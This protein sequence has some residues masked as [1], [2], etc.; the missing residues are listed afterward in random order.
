MDIYATQNK[1]V[2][3]YWLKKTQ[4][5]EVLSSFSSN[6]I[7]SSKLIL[8]TNSL[9]YFNKL[10]G[11]QL[12][13]EYTVLLSIYS[14]LIKKYFIDFDGFIFSKNTLQEEIVNANS[15]LF[16]ITT[17]QHLS[18]KTHLQRVKKE[19]QETLSY[20]QYNREELKHKIVNVNLEGLTPFSF[21]YV[22]SNESSQTPFQ[23]NV[24]KNTKGDIEAQI[25]YSRNFL[26][27][28]VVE[29]FLKNIGRILVNLED[30]LNV[31]INKISILSDKE[32][33]LITKHFNNTAVDYPRNRTI[34]DLFEEKVT[35][36]PNNTAVAFED[37]EIT[38]KELN[39]CTNQLAHYLR[40]EH[41]IQ[42][43]DLIGI[44]LERSEWLIVIIL[45]ILKAGA[46]YV[47][48]DSSYPQ[49]RI[50][51]IVKD[52]GLKV[53]I[54]E[55]ELAIFKL[56]SVKYS[57]VNIS[58]V[59][60]SDQLAY[61][62]Y[63]S[64]STG[65]PKGVLNSHEGL[66]NRLLWMRDYL[67]VTSTDIFLQKTPYTFDVSVWEFLLPLITGCVLVIAE[68]EG[69]KDPI[70][71]QELIRKKK[72]TIVHFVPSMLSVFL[73]G[74]DLD[75]CKS[76][77]HIICSGEALT[78]NIVEQ[79]KAKLKH[80]SIHNFYGPTEAAI[81]VT[82]I[83]LTNVKV[84]EQGVSIG[85]PVSNTKIYI[86]NE[87]GDLQPI[88]IPGE[89]LISGVQV[90]KGYLNLPQLTKER[91]IEDPFTKGNRMYRTGD[92][93]KWLPDGSIQYLG[94]RDHQ[95]KI[96]GYRIEL[97]E[98]ESNILEYSDNIKQV[99]VDVKETDEKKVLV[100]YYVSSVEI[101][102]TELKNYLQQKLPEYMIPSFYVALSNLPL[103]S[104]GKI[105]RKAL[106]SVKDED[107]AYKEYIAPTNKVEQK[108]VEIWKEVLGMK[109]IGITDN[110]FELGG[111][112]LMIT[113]VINRIYKQ[114]SCRI[115]F[116]EFL[117]AP[118][119]KNVSHKLHKE[120][121]AL[122]PKAFEMESYPLTPSQ[123][124]LWIL[125]QLEGA[126]QAYNMSDAIKI[127]GNFD[128]EKFENSFNQLIERHEILRTY[129]KISEVSGEIRQYIVPKIDINF[130]I[131]IKDF[132]K[133]ENQEV[134][135][136]DYLQEINNII[137]DLEKA[138]LIKAFLLKIKAAEY[139]FFLSLHHIIGDGWSIQLLI[140]EIVQIY[141]A[142]V[143]NK[144]ANLPKLNIQYKDYAVWLRE[145]ITNGQYQISKQY[146]LNQ[147]K[148][149]LP[150]LNLPSFKTRPQAQTYKGNTLTYSFS[151]EILES[152]KIF[153]QKNDVTLF[154][155]L[156]A[157]INALLYRYTGQHD[158]IIGTPV[159]GRDHPDLENQIGLYLNTLA[160][161]TELGQ[162]DT[163]IDLIHKER[164]ILFNAYEHQQY[165]FD[166]LL[167]SLNLKRD[168]GRSALFDIMV[169]L[170]NQQQLNLGSKQNG[171]EQIQ[172]SEYDFKNKTSKFD[173]T[174]IFIESDK[175]DLYIT[176]N[177]DIC[178]EHL[179]KRMFIHLKNLLVQSLNQ[180]EIPIQEIDYLSEEEKYELLITFN[181]TALDYPQNKTIV[182]LFE[183]Q[184]TKTPENIA[185]VFE[186]EKL[187]YRELNEK[188]NQFANYIA[189]NYFINKEDIIGV[190]MPKS[191]KV[192][193]SLL[194]I[195]KLGAAYLPIDINYPED[196]I[197]YL[198]ENSD[199]KLLISTQNILISKK[200]KSINPNFLDY[201]DQ[202]NKN[203][204]REISPKDLAYVIYTSGSTGKP[205]GV[206]IEHNSNVNMSL[207][208]IRIFKIT[209]RDNVVWFA[210]IAFDASISEI[211][212]A[213]YSG[214][215]L[216]IP[217]EGDIK[218]KEQFVCFLKKTQST[219]VTFPP[220]YLNLLSKADISG[221][222]NIITAGEVADTYRA[223]EIVKSGIQ[224]FNAYG[225]TECA[226][227]ASVYPLTEY[228][229]KQFNLPI[230]K[231]ISNI[232]IHILDDELRL[233]PTGVVGKLYIS[234]V[235]VGR[236][237]LNN[238]KLTSEK[239]KDNPFKE[240][241]RIYDTGD[242]AKWLP[243][244][245]I[246]FLGRNDC[247]IKIRGY[248]VELEEIE[249]MIISYSENLQQVVV[250]AKEVNKDKVLVAYL[251]SSSK[252]EKTKLRSFLQ[253][254]LPEY[255]VPNFYVVLTSIPLTLNGKIDRRALPNITEKD[256][257]YKEY[258]APR[259]ETEQE[260]VRIWQEVLGVKKIGITDNFFELGGHSLLMTQVINRISS[261][262][263]KTI[264]LKEFFAAPNIKD[265]SE[266]LKQAP[267]VSIP[268]AT[269]M[270]S[271]PLT[272]A[273]K[274]IWV[275]CK[276][277]GK[278]YI[279]NIP[280]LIK[281]N[282]A[283][284]ENLKDSLLKTIENN[285]IL[286]TNFIFDNTLLDI[287]QVVRKEVPALEITI[288]NKNLHEVINSLLLYEFNLE[289]ELLIKIY[290]LQQN[291]NAVL[292]IITHHIVID[293]KSVDLII[294]E[295]EDY[296][297]KK[298][299]SL[300]KKIQY[301]DY[302]VWIERIRR[303]PSFYEAREYW[304]NI[305][306][307]LISTKYKPFVYR[308]PIVENDTLGLDIELYKRIIQYIRQKNTTVNIFFCYLI[309]KSLNKNNNIDSI[310]FGLPDDGRTNI[311]LETLI[312]MFVNILP[313]K[314]SIDGKK[315][316]LEYMHTIANV[317]SDGKKHNIYQYDDLI[318]DLK[319]DQ[320]QFLDF[321]FS[322]ENT[323]H[324]V[325]DN[326]F[327]NKQYI[328]C[329]LNFTLLINE[330][331][332]SYKLNIVYDASVYTKK[333]IEN[334]KNGIRNLIH[335]IIN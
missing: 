71:L 306:A 13:A 218:D 193:I 81:D 75:K 245:N 137:F 36:T 9:A 210:S 321:L 134:V 147:F 62:I 297:Y 164:K 3:D 267:Y 129:F 85:Y 136:E 183:E 31:T 17:P 98:I 1:L 167:K 286:R 47:P 53:L 195:L 315:D 298:K 202:D 89:L 241:E 278:N 211:M 58:I 187:T 94:R 96:R 304:L 152:L 40:K 76:L 284:I 155:A 249:R 292:L 79:F 264:S 43:N 248:R 51:Y 19:V 265:I 180:P 296:Y 311:Q 335:E 178:D 171:M 226:V 199:V 325:A 154:V 148:G 244:G 192:V 200:T 101:D 146:W 217:S 88:G 135:I 28:Y 288:L 269:E 330:E 27:D 114:L 121:F 285:E 290:L 280:I 206:M 279:Y 41:N 141:N 324:L 207:D 82:A 276:A 15:L 153:S 266:K 138:P 111:N 182:D 151:Q 105:D 35:K 44:D 197:N 56:K 109:K 7:S 169:V 334:I 314:I 215:R 271:Y 127:I 331:A 140:S 212:M 198:I 102:K 246:A 2:K 203:L 250:E 305:Y 238:L 21:N 289:R 316:S 118:N 173:L 159:A 142:L 270:E 20:S 39:E 221:L 291:A 223:I 247:Q 299:E 131:D 275:S 91:F 57:K 237:Y 320:Y 268:T 224:Y 100:A 5:R 277:F 287:R 122:I 220:S 240:G 103:T 125:S 83:N 254:K 112:S 163:F 333:G 225:P 6:L 326:F 52:A 172:V 262:I 165:P 208:Q 156:M 24:I 242:L 194:A 22:I 317:I 110:F 84:H 144:E 16:L 104:N 301:K 174:F 234:G 11:N 115:T 160:I 55:E 230:G 158:I 313:I 329:K 133:E 119:I 243:D 73:A 190:L 99:V 117:A 61:C 26:E 309:L 150:V 49:E 323:N 177:T 232:N 273:Q 196:R 201:S 272:P 191:E 161:R 294:Q 149:E 209:E 186:E 185:V 8:G 145:E 319:I 30:Y 69:H 205:K 67:S 87:T 184:V 12:L 176:Y 113:Q 132:S 181:N 302:A 34:V 14:V 66:Y 175:L 157:G 188:A 45:A 130:K 90:A 332:N 170:Q 259:N 78:A 77:S 281:L 23:L 72:V 93:A 166:E 107:I 204:N 33:N 162:Q 123:H 228:N 213:L 260:L 235:G 327:Y 86:V 4:G 231:P 63:T 233:V 307:E 308:N 54:D 128:K 229:I 312:G 74:V 116:K 59:I 25:N 46:A 139:V 236:G 256:I 92:I 65:K 126:S 70:Y 261:Q 251:V 322:S 252:V 293:G 10:T 263:S 300:I 227:C 124:R 50:K 108:L 64:G 310:C 318:N 282:E 253:Q 255:M 283:D 274:K 216:N 97:G 179:V 106:P 80:T 143:Q 222:R 189:S 38:Y 48:I 328:M 257:I 32:L 295:F 120:N 219:V 239:F 60:K 42:P 37:K 95:L 258:I 29:H 168:M 68:P 214:A 303:E 18:L